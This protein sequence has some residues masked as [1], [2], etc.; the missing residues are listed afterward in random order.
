M[1][2]L[3]IGF[4]KMGMLHAATL[5]MLPGVSE[6]IVAES[7]PLIRRG[8][9]AFAPD[10]RVVPDYREALRE[11][12]LAGAVIATPT[13]SH[14]PIFKELA[15]S[16]RGIFVEKPF[17][18]GYRQAADAAAALPP[19]R[20]VSVMTG[21]C[22]RFSPVFL[23]AKRLI[24]AGVLKKPGRFEA[25]MF[26]SDVL[27]PSKSWR[28]KG[29][30]SGGGVL[31]DLGSHLIDITRHFFGTPCRLSGRTELVVSAQAED[32]FE[33]EW[34]YKNGLNGR[35]TGS[36]S[37][38]DCRKPSLS[39]RITGSNG[40]MEVF[41][42]G[43]EVTLHESAA[44]LAA[45]HTRLSVTSLERPVPFDLAGPMYTRQMEAW[46]QSLEGQ[47]LQTNTLEENL[48]NLRLIDAIRAAGGLDRWTDIA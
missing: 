44:G 4:G 26:S 6:V 3:V 47:P 28:F 18:A 25:S 34:N 40:Q 22:L 42:D 39:L 12:D 13:A 38:R 10:A 35:L 45:G 41:D 27:K 19:G 33:S 17:A 29:A 2:L 37:K 30:A 5:R 32:A 21:H 23:E 20:S 15:A 31:L 43:L 7:S 14:A 24:D 1:K 11:K 8:I 46:L 16:V 48:T 9:T 36:W